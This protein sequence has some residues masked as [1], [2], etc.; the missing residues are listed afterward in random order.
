M[1]KREVLVVENT[2]G[3]HARLA[4]Q[5]VHAA[6]KYESDILLKYKGWEIDVKSILGLMSL[7]IPEGERLE[8]VATGEDATEVINELKPI[9]SK[10]E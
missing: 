4:Q 7:A 3:I 5:I 8:I 9:L 10:I 2:T 1:I 6:S